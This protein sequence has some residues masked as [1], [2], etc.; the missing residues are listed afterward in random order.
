MVDHVDELKRTAIM[1]AVRSK[2]TTPEIALRKL[3]HAQGYRYRLHDKSLPGR[4]DIVF[5]ARKKAVFV[6]GCFWHRHEGCRY[7]TTPKS[8]VE[9]WEA[10]FE[11]NVA[12]D[13]RNILGL[14]QMGWAVAI[15]WQC[16]FK[17]PEQVLARITDF[18]EST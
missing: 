1:A 17:Q 2:D 5:P 8:R 14:K 16:E 12:R 10:K 7:A 3:L 9:F 13:R 4:P 15:V 11:A 18:L 6:N